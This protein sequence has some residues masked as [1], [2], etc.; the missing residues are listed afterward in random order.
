VR[1]GGGWGVTQGGSPAK[2]ALLC[3]AKVPVISRA[4]APLGKHVFHMLSSTTHR[5]R[6][7]EGKKEKK[8]MI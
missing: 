3:R 6:E 5:E 2:I 8:K 1:L 7:K 4:G